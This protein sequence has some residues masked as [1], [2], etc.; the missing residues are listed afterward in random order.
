LIQA[1][2]RAALDAEG[3]ADRGL[4]GPVLERRRHRGELLGVDTGGAAAMPTATPCRGQSGLDPFLDQRAFE[5]R[6]R[7][8]NVEQQLALRRG[9]IHLLGQRT[10]GD[11]T[12]LQI[13]HRG[14][15][16]RQRSAEPVQ[17]PDHQA[18][19]RSDESQRLG[20]PGTVTAASSRVILEQVALIDPGGE[21]RVT[22]QVHDLP[23]TAGGDAHVADQHVRKTSPKRF[24]H[25]AAFRHRL[26]YSFSA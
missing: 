14:Q 25:T 10:K 19:A 21:Q 16:M 2:Q 20:Q 11:A 5:L 6:E 4:G 8:E 3:S 26:S 18:V 24:P 22:L 12:L 1:D 23:V 17:L 13:G 9:G 7:P 15:Q